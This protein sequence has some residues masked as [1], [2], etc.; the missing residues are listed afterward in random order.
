M[1]GDAIGIMGWS[2]GGLNA[3]LAA[4]AYPDTFKAAVTWAGA[5]DMKNS[6][7]AQRHETA[8]KDGYTVTECLMEEAHGRRLDELSCLWRLSD[9]L[10]QH[11]GEVE[12]LLPQTK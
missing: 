1:D 8:K 4:A 11:V 12:T 6:D 10:E 5:T 9:Y 3:M 2:Q 7:F